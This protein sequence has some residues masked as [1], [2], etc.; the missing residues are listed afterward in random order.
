MLRYEIFSAPS[1]WANSGFSGASSGFGGKREDGNIRASFS[2]AAGA[3]EYG[4]AL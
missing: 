2:R 1:I 3:P 4:K